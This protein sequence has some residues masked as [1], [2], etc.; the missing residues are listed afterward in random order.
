MTYNFD[1]I[2][3]RI[4][5]NSYKWNVEDN[6]L[7]M[8]VADMDFKTAPSIQEALEKRVAHGIFG[9]TDIPDEWAKSYINW[10][11][12]RHQFKMEKDALIFCTGVVPAI[13]S[14]VRKLTTPGEN[15]LIQTPVYNIFFNSI[16]NNGRNVLQSPLSYDG[17]NYSIDFTQ[18]EKDL[19]NPQTSMMILCNPHNPIG[20]IWDKETLSK[21]GELCKKY[22]VIVLSD[23]IHCDIT[24][25]NESYIPFASVSD[26]C[27]EISITCIA[28]TKC[29]NIA[30]IQTSAVY[31]YDENLRHKVWRGLNTDE[32]AEPNA[33]AIEAAIAAF[34]NGEEWLDALRVYIQKNKDYAKDYITKNLPELH[35][36]D[37]KSTYL[38]WIDCRNVTND[39]KEL[40]SFIRQETGLYVS[41][42]SQ[43]G[44]CGDTFIRV[45]I[46]TPLS[47][48]KEGL[49]RLKRG[50]QLYH[51]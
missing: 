23:E 29:F 30:G 16:V 3:N 4:D 42:G 2:V 44:E 11:E 1:E 21:I 37:S 47:S 18:L 43:Y 15:V 26:T 10:W 17:N 12:R 19:S 13:S 39:S 8:W 46:A 40:T 33:F 45:N 49:E 38:L 14:I 48:V 24:S 50:I 34:D 9:Y 25:P 28:P 20:K 36:I 22:H 27:K 32:V 51:Q 7:P 5:T 6:E 41:E 35:M 31:V